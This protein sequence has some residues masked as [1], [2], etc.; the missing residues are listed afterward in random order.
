[1]NV[2]NDLKENF[3]DNLR[4]KR[5]W[6]VLFFLT[7]IYK[8]LLDFSYIKILGG[9]IEPFILDINHT[10]ILISTITVAGIFILI[11]Q[12][13]R[14]VSFLLYNAFFYIMVLPMSTI[15]GVC[16]KSTVYFASVIMGS[17]ICILIIS[18][19]VPNT[20]NVV[21]VIPESNWF[22][23]L[24]GLLIVVT[25]LFILILN[26]G[27]P[28]LNALDFENVYEIRLHGRFIENKL[29]NYVFTWTV[30]VI[31]PFLICVAF[32]YKKY[33]IAIV[34]ISIDVIFY[35]YTGNKTI[36]FSILLIVGMYFILKFKFSNFIMGMCLSLGMSLIS[37][38]GIIGIYNPYSYFVRRVMILP[39]YLKFIYYDFFE[40]RPKI[41]MAG[42]LLGSAFGQ[43]FPYPEGIG[44]AISKFFFNNDIMN[45]NTGFLAEGYYR[46]GVLG[47]II[48]CAIL[49]LLIRLIE[50]LSNR[51]SFLF[52]TIVSIYPIYT[53]NDR[54]LIDSLVFGP[55][56]IFVLIMI[57]YSDKGMEEKSHEP[58]IKIQLH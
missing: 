9:R 45:S 19:K 42:T 56:L 13:R 6:I 57:F 40:C 2:I 52:A 18:K 37:I 53:L 3:R 55:M 25:I 44:M 17:L 34:L 8:G 10:K 26:V 35:L 49:G 1:M 41:G 20:R 4:N 54:S 21:G 43:K 33:C 28:N 58:R 12:F 48:S 5:K 50:D 7:M 16:D 24:F 47:V 51:T 22:I 30:T 29:F 36:F 39:A 38:A 14:Q 32:A 11:N 23:P 15:Y 46:Y 31:L 27:I